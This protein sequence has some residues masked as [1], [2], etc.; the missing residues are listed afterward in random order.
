MTSQQ[1]PGFADAVIA[2]ALAHFA[3]INGWLL[4]GRSLIRGGDRG[5]RKTALPLESLTSFVAP[6]QANFS[7]VHLLAATQF[8]SHSAVSSNTVGQIER[9]FDELRKVLDADGA[10][11]L[12]WRRSKLELD[13]FHRPH[14]LAWLAL[15]GLRIE[16]ESWDDASSG[17]LWLS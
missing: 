7:G 5:T 6:G 15:T 17:Y 16:H 9:S 3:S 1:K 14:L 13:A 11:V 2:R 4:E 10:V 8:A 12:S